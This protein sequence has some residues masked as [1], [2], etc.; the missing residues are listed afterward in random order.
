VVA[1]V[2]EPV[3]DVRRAGGDDVAGGGVVDGGG[4]ATAEF[5]QAAGQ[6]LHEGVS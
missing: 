4:N 5:R 1:A 6:A 3:A 2:G